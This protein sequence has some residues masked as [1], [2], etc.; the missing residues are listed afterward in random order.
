MVTLID[1]KSDTTLSSDHAADQQGQ[2]PDYMEAI[3]TQAA[4]QDA[5]PPSFSEPGGSS[6]SSNPLSS[7]ANFAPLSRP[8]NYLTVESQHSPIKGVYSID[9]TLP[10]PPGAVKSQDK[11]GNYLNLRLA[12]KHGSISAVIDVVR[13]PDAKGP[14]KLETS[15]KHGGT[16]ITIVC[17]TF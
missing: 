10:A 7:A 8:T 5:P 9:P 15:C 17:P 3:G 6:S 4:H 16:D 14:A 11:D 12:A 13:G 1:D 2:P